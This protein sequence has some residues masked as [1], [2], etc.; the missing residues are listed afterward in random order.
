MQ[1]DLNNNTFQNH[2]AIY[3]SSLFE[4]FTFGHKARKLFVFLLVRFKIVSPI[5]GP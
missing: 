1:K 5:C 4:I 3:S 2:V